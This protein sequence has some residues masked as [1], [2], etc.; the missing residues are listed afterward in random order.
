MRDEQRIRD[1]IATVRVRDDAETASL[2]RRIQR[3]C[4]PGGAVDR[5]EPSAIRWLQR[6]RPARAA[7]PVP[8]CSC[9]RG[10][11]LVCN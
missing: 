8:S 7:G 9:S 2:I 5:R 1:H 3:N 10:Y 6:W 4:W 11:C